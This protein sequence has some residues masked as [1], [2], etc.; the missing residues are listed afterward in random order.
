MTIKEKNFILACAI[1]DGCISRGFIQNSWLRYRFLLKHSEKQKEYFHWKCKQLESILS[2]SK[3]R[4]KYWKLYVNSGK[5]QINA[6]QYEKNNNKVL[7]PIYNLLYRSNKKTLSRKVLDKFDAQGLAI[8]YMDDGSLS[9]YKYKRG[10]GTEI[11]RRC[12]ATL[13]TYLSKEENIIIQKYFREKWNV[14]WNI[15]KDKGFFRL[16]CGTKEFRKFKQIIEPYI[17]ETMKYKINIK[18]SQRAT[19]KPEM[20]GDDI[21]EQ[22]SSNDCRE[23]VTI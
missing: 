11:Y 21:V 3:C 12:V 2:K 16:V 14:E 22:S 7:K 19:P 1:G 9:H 18:V 13:N 6:L 23:K 8:W 15:H 10:D 5:S 17:H 20:V 4:V